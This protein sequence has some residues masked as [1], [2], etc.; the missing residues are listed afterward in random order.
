MTPAGERQGLG[1]FADCVVL[2]REPSAGKAWTSFQL[3]DVVPVSKLG[4]AANLSKLSL[5]FLPCPR[6]E[7][8]YGPGKQCSDI[9]VRDLQLRTSAPT[10][11]D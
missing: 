6:L 8:C 2:P 4:G 1:Q 3:N 10:Q 11:S 9:E 7:S 5:A